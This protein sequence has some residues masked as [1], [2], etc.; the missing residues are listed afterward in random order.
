[1]EASIRLGISLFVPMSTKLC[2]RIGTFLAC[3]KHAKAEGEFLRRSG[4]Y[5]HFISTL[6]EFLRELYCKNTNFLLKHAR[7]TNCVVESQILDC[8][9]E[10][11]RI[12]CEEVIFT[13]FDEEES[14]EKQHN[15]ALEEVHFA[16]EFPTADYVVSMIEFLNAMDL[17]RPITVFVDMKNDTDGALKKRIGDLNVSL[18]VLCP[19]NSQQLNA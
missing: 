12:E 9:L 1:M 10:T 4:S 16:F 8:V 6:V 7:R 18:P 17:G 19:D 5:R 13:Y 14:V 2:R 3:V 11:P 15:F